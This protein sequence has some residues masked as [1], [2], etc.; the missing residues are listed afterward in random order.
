MPVFVNGMARG[1]VP[2]GHPSWMTLARKDALRR[3]D[4]VVI[5]GT[6]LDFRLGYGKETHIAEDARLIQVDLDGGEIGRNRAIDVGIVGDT[7]LVMEQMTAVARRSGFRAGSHRA[8]TEEIRGIDRTRRQ[9]TQAEMESDATPI[10]PVRACA[11]I[12][13]VLDAVS[14]THL[15]LPTIC[16][17]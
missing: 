1:S 5:F 16:S 11:E 8:W 6:P 3:A 2:P 12:D 10:N 13:A 4:V 9:A 15:T 7:G 17:V 14:Y